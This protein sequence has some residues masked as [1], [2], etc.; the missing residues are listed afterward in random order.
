MRRCLKWAAS[1]SVTTWKLAPTR[2]RLT[3]PRFSRTTVGEGTKID[4]PGPDRPQRGHRQALHPLRPQVG[5]SSAAPPLRIMWCWVARRAWAATL[6]SA[7]APRQAGRRASLS[8][9]PRRQR[10]LNG[11]L[12]IPYM[13]GT[14]VAVILHQRLPDLFKRV[15]AIEARSKEQ[16]SK[17]RSPEVEPFRAIFWLPAP[18]LHVSLRFCPSRS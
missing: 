5:I 15:E 10:Y 7:R 1:L 18:I 11:T 13:D 9:R 4:N 14:P 2:P 17:E 3:A 12:A 16:E 6:P 8:T